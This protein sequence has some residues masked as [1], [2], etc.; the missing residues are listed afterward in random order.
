MSEEITDLEELKKFIGG[1]KSLFNIK[2]TI[3]D[4]INKSNIDR[5]TRIRDVELDEICRMFF[6]GIRHSAF[7]IHGKNINI[8]FINYEEL[9]D[10]YMISEILEYVLINLSLRLSLNSESRKELENI[11]TAMIRKEIDR[12][13]NE[14]D[15]E[16]K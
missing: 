12:I 5:I 9:T 10:N 1:G 15:K 13:E 4:F 16:D 11:A 3:A 6:Y 7:L 14:N 2:D 8:S